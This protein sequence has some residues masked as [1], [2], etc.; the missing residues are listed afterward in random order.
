MGI[1]SCSRV[2]FKGTLGSFNRNDD[3]SLQGASCSFTLLT[4]SASMASVKISEM[5]VKCE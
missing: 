5:E 2:L 3:P 1:G 4:G